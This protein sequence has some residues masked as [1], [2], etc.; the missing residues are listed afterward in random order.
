MKIGIFGGSFNPVHLGHQKIVK[1]ILQKMKLDKILVIPV[2]IPSHRENILESGLHR[3]HMCQLAFEHLKEVEVLDIEIKK[4]E[5]CYTYDTLLEIQN[6]YGKNQEYFEI[7]G[8]DSLAYF[9]S[10]K[11]ADEILKL[12]K[13]LVLQRESFQLVSQNPSILLLNSPTFPVSSTEIRESL[14]QGKEEIAWLAPKI[15]EYIQRHKLYKK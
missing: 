5:P 11:K 7:I 1:Y 9:D 4:K 2:G 6:I 10:W 8:E 3:F 13:L 12:S 14:Q 15:L